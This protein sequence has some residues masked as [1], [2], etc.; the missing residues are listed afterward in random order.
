MITVCGW[1]SAADQMLPNSSEMLWRENK[2]ERGFELKD[3]A[4]NQTENCQAV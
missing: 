3:V 4:G 1:K 2:A